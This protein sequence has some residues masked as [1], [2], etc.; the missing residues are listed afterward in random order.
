MAIDRI[1]TKIETD[2]GTASQN[3][4]SFQQTARITQ[5]VSITDPVNDT[6]AAVLA[7]F[8]VIQLR[9]VHPFNQFLRCSE[10]N[11]R[12]TSVN[13]YE[14]GADY[15]SSG[16]GKPNQSPLDQPPI[17]QWG[18]DVSED[19]IDITATGKPILMKTGEPP[20]PRLRKQYRDRTITITKNLQRF[21]DLLF[22]MY[23]AE[24]GAVNSDPFTIAGITYP[25]GTVRLTQP[26]EAQSVSDDNFTYFVVTCGLTIRRI[27]DAM[28]STTVFVD[29]SKVNYSDQHAWYRRV[30]AQ[31][32]YGPVRG[33]SPLKFARLFDDDKRPVVEPMLHDPAT[34]FPIAKDTTTGV[35][36]PTKAA[37]YAFQVYPSL[38]FSALNIT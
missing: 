28:K 37:W 4:V 34:G 24:G 5:E 29:G 11:A 32:F 30:L 20:R 25:A 23:A 22:C 19:E 14:V 33:T 12:R 27:P 21:D 7:A 10:V 38:P 13:M 26:G 3:N 6:S 17:I 31:G 1:T 9:S 8:G 16:Q 36:D 15:S 2:Y 18:W 35:Q